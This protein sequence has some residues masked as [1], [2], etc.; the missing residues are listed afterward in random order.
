MD[1]YFQDKN[2]IKCPYEHALYTKAQSG[3]ILIVR[4]YVDEL[5]FTWN[6]LSMFK[7]FKKDMSN[8]FEMTDMGLMVYYLGIKVKQED[9]G[10]FITQEGYAKEV[11]KKFKMD[12]ANPVGTLMGCGSKLSKHENGEIVD[13]TLYKSLVGSL[14]YLT[15]TRPNVLYVV[16]VVSRYMEAPTTTHFKATKRILRYIKGTINFGLHYYSSNNYEIIG[17]SD[18]DWSG[19]LDDRKST[20]GFVFFMG[21]TAFT[22]MSK[23]QPI[24]H[25]QLVKLSML[26]PH[27]VF[28]MQFG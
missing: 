11:L 21:D 12:D 19:D 9:K 15:S 28:V 2:F 10:I 6:N 23:K 16:G 7:E 14:C 27:H 26:P 8:E 4:L 1:K 13:P 3:D 24:A 25:C 20:I 22:W 18:S 17:Y 5:I